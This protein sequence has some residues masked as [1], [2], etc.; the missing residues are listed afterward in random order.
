MIHYKI[1]SG[2]ER[3]NIQSSNIKN[4]TPCGD[5]W[6]ELED[7]F[8]YEDYK[9]IW[10][11]DD[12]YYSS[13]GAATGY[14]FNFNTHEWNVI[15]FNIGIYGEHVWYHNNDICYDF[16]TQHYIFNRNTNQWEGRTWGTNKAIY[17][18]CVWTDG[19]DY[20][21]S[22]T[23]HSVHYDYKL[24]L[25]LQWEECNWN[26]TIDGSCVYYCNDLTNNND[27]VYFSEPSLNTS[28]KLNKNT[29][30]WERL[31]WNLG[32]YGLYKY[33]IWTD[34]TYTYT[35]DGLLRLD[36]NETW[37]STTWTLPSTVGDY[38]C[39][40]M[41]D[42]GYLLDSGYAY[43]NPL[44]TNTSYSNVKFN[45]TWGDFIPT[46]LE[47]VSMLNGGSWELQDENILYVSSFSNPT[48]DD[49]GEEH[50]EP[51]FYFTNE[52]GIE[53]QTYAVDNEG[54]WYSSNVAWFSFWDTL[55][56]LSSNIRR[57]Y[58][59]NWDDWD[60]SYQPA[61]QDDYE[62]FSAMYAC[63][64]PYVIVEN[65]SYHNMPNTWTLIQDDGLYS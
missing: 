2:N 59:F 16:G 27:N 55:S 40:G 56:S 9:S 13:S 3:F 35:R 7:E 21:Y 64:S 32:T 30:N 58:I 63:H 1:Y 4:V 48:Y 62:W 5:T 22:D 34:G 54:N 31:Y 51:G 6:Y 29:N 41:L 39:I 24:S 38:S 19:I 17:G 57:I 65:G 26:I 18:D 36:N 52:E 45:I 61:G 20:Y 60:Y 12:T 25:S 50:D 33:D 28:Y 53:M 44:E 46:P 11:V 23:N 14:V 42:G 37:V 49:E 10:H 15:N 47:Y 8:H 43:W